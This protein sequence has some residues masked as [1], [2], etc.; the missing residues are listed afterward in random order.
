MTL[1]AIIVR[2]FAGKIYDLGKREER[3]VGKDEKARKSVG[4][5]RTRGSSF[6]RPVYEAGASFTPL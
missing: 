2:L 1:G 5:R 6:K 4:K 3:K